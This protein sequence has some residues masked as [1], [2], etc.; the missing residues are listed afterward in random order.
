MSP[1][2]QS[3]EAKKDHVK[4]LQQKCKQ[5]P[6]QKRELEAKRNELQDQKKDCQRR[7]NDLKD[8]Q[9]G[10]RESIK[11]L[12]Y[13]VKILRAACATYLQGTVFL[14]MSNVVQCKRTHC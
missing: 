12:E 5:F 4:Q 13:K 9:D 2:L 7:E 11:K 14:F 8:Q 1:P 6:S 3:L 10:L